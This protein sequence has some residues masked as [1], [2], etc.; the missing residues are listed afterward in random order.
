VFF[1]ETNDKHRKVLWSVFDLGS[2]L[3]AKYSNYKLVLKWLDFGARRSRFNSIEPVDQHPR[4]RG[5]I[6]LIALT[7]NAGR[8]LSIS[9]IYF[10][11]GECFVV[12]AMLVF[13]IFLGQRA[14]YV[15]LKI[16]L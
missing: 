9:S 10:C 12:I 2:Q 4:E 5:S 13:P 8:L 3:G 1:P 7:P 6:G 11:I 16:I 15:P 14:L